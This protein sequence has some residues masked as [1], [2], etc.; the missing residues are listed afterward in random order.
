MV[1]EAS[2]LVVV[3]GVENVIIIS[4]VFTGRSLLL[5]PSDVFVTFGLVVFF[6]GC[7]VRTVRVKLVKSPYLPSN[8]EILAQ[9]VPRSRLEGVPY[10][11]FDAEKFNQAAFVSMDQVSLFCGVS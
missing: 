7:V 9:Y 11:L 3:I 1:N 5:I 2:T 6:E 4:D 10:N 8:T